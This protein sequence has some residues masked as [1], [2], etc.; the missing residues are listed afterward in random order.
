M[1][2]PLLALALALTGASAQSLQCSSSVSLHTDFLA[3]AA[4]LKVAF[5]LHTSDDYSK[6][7]HLCMSDYS[8]LVLRPDGR[9]TEQKLESIDDTWGRSIRFGIDGFA[10]QGWQV[11]ARII[12]A[13]EHPTFQVVVY[14]LRTERDQE[15]ELPQEFLNTIAR[16]CPDSL[17]VIGTTR[18]GEPVIAI[19]RESCHRTAKAWKLTQGSL[20]RGVQKPARL[21]PLSDISAIERLSPGSTSSAH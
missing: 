13:G 2:P 14:D 1:F 16:P 11:I 8:F 12:E 7:T 20:I 21:T 5:Q 6:E 9:K 17:Q 18:I 15:L 19:E 3:A 4:G 10:G